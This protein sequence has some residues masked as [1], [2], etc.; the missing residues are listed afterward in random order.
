[1]VKIALIGAGSV[2]FAQTLVRDILLEPALAGCEI[3]LMDIS[4][5]RLDRAAAVMKLLTKRIGASPKF[6]V[7][8]DLREAVR[9]ADYVITIFRSGTLEHQ[10][11]E[12]EVPMKYKVDQ[13]VSDKIG[14]ASCRERV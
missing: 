2:G 1:M 6:L 7:T 9:K 12:Y 10:R 14:R 4:R 11:L 8:T 5:E 13:V 3:A